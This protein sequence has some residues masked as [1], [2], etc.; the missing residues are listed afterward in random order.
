VRVGR[1]QALQGV[2]VL[3][4]EVVGEGA[5]ALE[6]PSALELDDATLAAREQRVVQR[7]VAVEVAEGVL[8]RHHERGRVDAVEH[9][10]VRRGVRVHVADR[11]DAHAPGAEDDVAVGA[12]CLLGE[13]REHGAHGIH[14]RDGERA[15]VVPPVDVVHPA[16]LAD[17]HQH[18]VEAGRG[19]VELVEAGRV[20]RPQVGA[21]GVE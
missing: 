1:E 2:A 6:L 11:T 8:G 5:V 19:G 13:G 18:P 20:D 7:Q 10:G 12:L 21:R 17:P 16:R 15:V 9:G 3:R 4:P 14:A